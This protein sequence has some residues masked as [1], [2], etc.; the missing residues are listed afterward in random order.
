MQ[1]VY[2]RAVV[3]EAW[4]TSED[5]RRRHLRRWRDTARHWRRLASEADAAGLPPSPFLDYCIA[6]SERIVR[7][8]IEGENRE[9]AR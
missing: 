8:L 9:A 2:P 1:P 7:E 4:F 5:E 3:P 6:E